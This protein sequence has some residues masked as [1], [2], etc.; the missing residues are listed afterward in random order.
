L[1]RP[2]TEV[3]RRGFD[4][5]VA[6][7]QLLLLRFAENI[8]FVFLAIATVIA[9]IAPLIISIGLSAINM[10]DVQA[11]PDAV[12]ATL[13]TVL[14][15]HWVVFVY[16]FA[17][18]FVLLGIFIIIHSFV[19]A[20]CAQTYVDADRALRPRVFSMER[21]LA[22]GR[23]SM[24]PVFW[25]YNGAYTIAALVVLVPAVLVLIFMLVL[26]ESAGALVLGCLALG[27]IVFVMVVVAV[28]TGIWCQKAIIVA[29][30][31]NLG[32]GEALRVAWREIRG[33]F[34]RHFAVAFIMLVIS[35]GGAATLGMFSFAFAMPASRDAFLPLMFA[36]ARIALSMVQNV[37]SAAV[38]LWMLACFAA[39]SDSLPRSE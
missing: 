28:L 36:P 8:V 4:S 10:K 34:G 29:V 18:I 32:A 23:H 15:S 17:A 13:A 9:V 24:W 19:I 14:A 37:F 27:L 30:R 39:L 33:D 35:I 16:A 7:W 6:N 11:N 1:K 2:I 5:A 38:T 21:W 31:C 26:R 22:G 3:I 20:G 25:I 12:A